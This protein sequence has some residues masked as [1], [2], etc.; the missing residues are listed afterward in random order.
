MTV[1]ANKPAFS[2]REKLKE[3]QKPIGLKGSELM[4]AETAQDARDF[5]SAGRKNMIINGDMRI[6]QRNSGSAITSPNIGIACDRWKC[7]TYVTDTT[8]QRSTTA[9]PGFSHSHLMTN[10]TAV[11]P[12]LSTYYQ[13]IWQIIEG[14]NITRLGWGTSNAKPISISFWVRSS[15]PGLYSFGLGNGNSPANSNNNRS[16]CQTF[17]INSANTWEYKTFT[18]PGCPSGTWATDNT[19]GLTIAF[20]LGSGTAYDTN[21]P[22][23]WSSSSTYMHTSTSSTIEFN[24][25]TGATFY[26]TG[27]QLEVGKNATEFEHRSYGEE[28]ALCQRYYQRIGKVSSD[29]NTSRTIMLGAYNATRAFGGLPISVAMR[30]RTPTITYS[31]LYLESFSLGSFLAIT[32]FSRYGDMGI[33]GSFLGVEANVASGLSSGSPYYISFQGGQNG[34]LALDTEL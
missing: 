25:I 31:N 4:R 11:A 5:V 28:L 17:T 18:I 7:G 21:S 6:D 8:I 30:T 13:Q 10:G 34:F 9:P 27:V 12:A 32:Y 33:D 29:D 26:L 19:Y 23:V 22:G 16:F 1:R 15:A 14:F 2:I 24:N 20:N 3:L